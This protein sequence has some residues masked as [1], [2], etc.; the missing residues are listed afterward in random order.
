[1]HFITL[2]Y[3]IKCYFDNIFASWVFS[4]AEMISPPT[5]GVKHKLIQTERVTLNQ[6]LMLNLH[7]KT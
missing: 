5:D 2:I 7:H 6:H 4:P 1:M 3:K